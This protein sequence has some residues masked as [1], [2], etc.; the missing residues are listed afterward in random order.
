MMEKMKDEPYV[1]RFETLAIAK[2]SSNN[3]G[4]RACA[5]YN[6]NEECN[7]GKWHLTHKPDG[8][9]TTHGLQRQMDARDPSTRPSMTRRNELR[10]HVCTLCLEAL[11]AAMG[12]RVLDCPWILKK[13]WTKKQ[14][15]AS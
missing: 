6:R 3:L 7:L 5:R 8:M 4:Y 9:W 15:N 13:N 14:E 2:K 12:H 11:G 10:L 1:G